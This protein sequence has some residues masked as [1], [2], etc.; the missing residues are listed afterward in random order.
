VFK[1]SAAPWTAFVHIQEI[2]L[3]AMTRTHQWNTLAM[4]FLLL[5][6][7]IQAEPVFSAA[8]S[9]VF[10]LQ[11]ENNIMDEEHFGVINGLATVGV[12][13]KDVFSLSGFWSPPYVSSDF[14][15]EL[16]LFGEKVPASHYVWRPFEVMREGT[17]REINV[18]T[19]TTL[20]CKYRAGILSISLINTGSADVQVPLDLKLNGTLD[21]T[22]VWEFSRS[23]SQTPA[24][25]ALLDNSLIK[26]QGDCALVLQTSEKTVSWNANTSSGSAHVSLAAGES[27][28]IYVC[29]GIG[30]VSIADT[31]RLLLTDTPTYIEQSRAEYNKRIEDLF[32]K[33]PRLTSDN[34]ALE[35]F[36][37]RSLVHFFTNRWETPEFVLHPY[38]STGSI[39]GGCVCNYL[40]NFGEV[41]EILPLYDPQAAREHIKQFLKIDITQHFAFIPTSGEAFGPWYM[42]NQ[43]K[44]LGLIY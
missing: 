22:N 38:Y 11:G 25:A 29:F 41:W 12:N 17:I 36:Y 28:T 2:P 23:Q 15:L 33:L 6:I 37:N 26:T 4:I 21:K 27:K 16:M 39:K 8:T 30:D 3:S 13:Y 44:I 7:C 43:E 40:W 32:S 9:D 14:S 18:L 31:C 19:A 42:V 5:T 20:P 24:P 34:P 35:K 1:K 10:A